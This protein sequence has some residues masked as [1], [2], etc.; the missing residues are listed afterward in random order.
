MVAITTL[1][2]LTV[3]LR[4]APAAAAAGA[5]VLRLSE[6]TAVLFDEAVLT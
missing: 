3:T 1:L 5:A 4:F 6:V 2:L